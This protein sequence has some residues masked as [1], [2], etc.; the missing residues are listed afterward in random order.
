MFQSLNLAAQNVKEDVYATHHTVFE[1]EGWKKNHWKKAPKSLGWNGTT[2][3]N[4]E[5]YWRESTKKWDSY[6]NPTSKSKLEIWLSDASCSNAWPTLPFGVHRGQQFVLC[7]SQSPRT[8]IDH[9]HKAREGG[10]L[11]FGV[12]LV[13]SYRTDPNSSWDMHF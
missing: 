7:G 5:T 8:I 4:F 10:K 13:R 3:P 12:F 6:F 2:F 1:F 11:S 9:D